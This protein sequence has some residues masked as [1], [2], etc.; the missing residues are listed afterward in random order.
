[1]FK[2]LKSLLVVSMLVFIGACADLYELEDDKIHEGNTKPNPDIPET[3][4]TPDNNVYEIS[5]LGE[6]VWVANKS[7]TDN[8]AGKIV[9]FMAD[10]DMENKQFTGIQKFAGR[11]EGNHKT[12]SNVN[13]GDNGDND[14]GLINE[15]EDGG[16]IENLTIASGT[17]KGDQFLGIFVGSAS[18]TTTIDGVTNNVDVTGNNYIGGIVGR[19]KGNLTIMNSVNTGTVTGQKPFYEELGKS[20]IGGLIGGDD[21]WSG[22]ALT[23]INSSN[24]GDIVGINNSSAFSGIGGLIG[25][26]NKSSLIIK[27]SSNSGALSG[28]GLIGG[29]VGNSQDNDLTISNSLNIGNVS[30]TKNS[31]GLIGR[32]SNGTLHI[33][34]SSNTANILAKDSSIGGF[35]GNGYKSV[36]TVENSFHSGDVSGSAMVGGII[37]LSDANTVVIKNVYSYSKSLTIVGASDTRIGGIIGNIYSGTVTANNVYWLYDNTGTTAGID[38]AVGKGVF[39]NTDTASKALTIAEFKSSTNFNAWDFTGDTGIWIM[40]AEYPTIRNLP[41]P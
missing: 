8:F 34:N 6:L 38:K 36:I 30:S 1:M 7:I 22:S 9:R 26:S 16:H 27:N 31:G 37:G 41:K 28:E 3:E 23:I 4:I 12:I 25:S 5:T 32:Y 21:S 18:G 29:L 35:V 15:L 39:T 19:N 24:S 17:I 20:V 13:I 14:I 11:L 33:D 10:I 40:G 2:K